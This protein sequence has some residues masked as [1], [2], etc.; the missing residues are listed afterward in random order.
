MLISGAKLFLIVLLVMSLKP[1]IICTIQDQILNSTY[2]K[3]VIFH[4]GVQQIV[5]NP[6]QFILKI[7]KTSS[8]YCDLIRVEFNICKKSDKYG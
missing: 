8:I 3:V 6:Y 2:D 1:I 5:D 4:S 7:S